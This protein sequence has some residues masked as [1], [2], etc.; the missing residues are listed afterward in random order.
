MFIEGE[1]G[2]GGLMQSSQRWRSGEG[3]FRMEWSGKE[4]VVNGRW[5]S[6]G[7]EVAW[8]GEVVRG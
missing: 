8:H 1:G 4:G 2:E 5:R 6:N 7:G 3:G